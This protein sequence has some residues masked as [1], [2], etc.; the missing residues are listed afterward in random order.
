MDN[1]CAGSILQHVAESDKMD[2]PLLW[3]QKYVNAMVALCNALMGLINLP[4]AWP[5]QTNPTILPM[6]GATLP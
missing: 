6:A 1:G 3:C 4:L 2:A 5:G